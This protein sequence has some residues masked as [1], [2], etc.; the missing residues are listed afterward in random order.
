MIQMVC[1]YLVRD[2][3]HENIHD[4]CTIC[5]FI[6]RLFSLVEEV[7]GVQIPQHFMDHHGDVF[8]KCDGLGG[9][10][11]DTCQLRAMQK[12]Q[13]WIADC[14][15]SGACFVEEGGLP[16]NDHSVHMPD[17]VAAMDSQVGVLGIAETPAPC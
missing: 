14:E 11:L 3:V 10:F 4:Q 7:A 5:H 15:L 17:T 16:T 8:L 9:G 12:E 6:V 2:R 1:L 13:E